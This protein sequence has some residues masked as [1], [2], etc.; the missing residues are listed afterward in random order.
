MPYLRQAGYSPSQATSIA[1][2]YSGQSP[3]NIPGIGGVTQNEA[4]AIGGLA[5][6]LSAAAKAYAD[7]IK[8]WQMQSDAVAQHRFGPPAAPSGPAAQFTQQQ[9]Q[10]P[11]QQRQYNPYGMNPYAMGLV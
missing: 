4:G 7:S 1:S 11:Q 5:S 3:G 10:Q 9:I 6:G 8:P 2:D